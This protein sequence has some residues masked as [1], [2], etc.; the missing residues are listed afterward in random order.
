MDA[1]GDSRHAEQ[2]DSHCNQNGILFM[3]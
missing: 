2:G 1:H 3:G